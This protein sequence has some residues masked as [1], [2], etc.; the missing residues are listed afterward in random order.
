MNIFLFGSF[1]I[2]WAFSTLSLFYR[3]QE[4][5][6]L[7]K[8]YLTIK[9]PVAPTTPHCCYFNQQNTNVLT[10]AHAHAESHAQSLTHVVT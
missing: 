6:W 1:Y 4:F 8:G 3:V 7:D 2:S 10:F 5:P 9:G